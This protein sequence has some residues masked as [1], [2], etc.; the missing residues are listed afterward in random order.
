VVINTEAG[1]EASALTVQEQRLKAFEN[2]GEEHTCIWDKENG[3]S[4][5]YC[6]FSRQA[7]LIAQM[8]IMENSKRGD[9]HSIFT[10]AHT[11]C[12]IKCE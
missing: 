10:S 9:K 6:D 3:S 11:H 4:S 2:S 8:G 12:I 1:R 7:M 5:V